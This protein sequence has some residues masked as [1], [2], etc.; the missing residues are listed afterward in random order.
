MVVA[1]V[2]NGGGDGLRGDKDV[3]RLTMLVSPRSRI[4]ELSELKSLMGGTDTD[5]KGCRSNSKLAAAATAR[6]R[7]WPAYKGEH[8]GASVKSYF[9][10]QREGKG[11]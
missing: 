11:K 2:I 6:W 4:A 7:G 8:P 10:S 9:K 1:M 5:T 3:A